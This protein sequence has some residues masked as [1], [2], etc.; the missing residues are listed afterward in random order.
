MSNSIRAGYENDQLPE[1]KPKR[2]TTRKPKAAAT[3]PMGFEWHNISMGKVRLL[4]LHDTTNRDLTLIEF[5]HVVWFCKEFNI[6]L[7]AR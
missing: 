2:A 3:Q 7:V 5:N 4:G 6:P 1:P